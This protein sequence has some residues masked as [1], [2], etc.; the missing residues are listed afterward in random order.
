MI[1]RVYNYKVINSPVQKISSS[2]KEGNENKI[3]GVSETNNA[4]LKTGMI[5][6]CLNIEE[7]IEWKK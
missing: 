6:P 4:S 5:W 2:G 1:S 7:R 3:V